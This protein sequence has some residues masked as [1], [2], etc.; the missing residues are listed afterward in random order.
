MFLAEGLNKLFVFFLITVFSKNNK[1]FVFFLITVFSKN[2]QKSL[3]LIERFCGFMKATS[4]TVIDKSSLQYFLNGS[5]D[6]HRAS[7]SYGSH[8][9]IISFDIR[10]DD[11]ILDDQ[12]NTKFKM[13]FCI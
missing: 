12:L 2:T 8:R 4:K 7:I 13:N 3:P 11:K 6:V 10:H 5:I 1:L 9:Y